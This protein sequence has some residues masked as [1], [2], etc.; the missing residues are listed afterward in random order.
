M[1][2]VFLRVG[3]ATLGPNHRLKGVNYL[4]SR[5]AIKTINSCIDNYLNKPACLISFLYSNTAYSKISNF[6]TEFEESVL[7]CTTLS[8][9]ETN[10]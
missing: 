7:D 2:V 8:V 5:S 10:K 4:P 6:P 3:L 1:F 9:N